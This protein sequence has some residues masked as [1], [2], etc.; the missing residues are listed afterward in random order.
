[1]GGGK[2]GDVL[3]A[4][5]LYQLG[6]GADGEAVEEVPVL[7]GHVDGLGVG[8][9]VD[10]VE[11]LEELGTGLR[12]LLDAG[13]VPD[14]LVVKDD[15][16]DREPR[17]RGLLAVE[18][19]GRVDVLRPVGADLLLEVGQVGQALGLRVGR[20]LSVAELDDVQRIRLR[21]C[22]GYLLLNSVPLLNF[23]LQLGSGLLFEGGRYVFGPPIRCG[24]VDS[25]DGQGFARPAA[26][27]GAF[28]VVAVRP[29]GRDAHQ[30]GRD[31]RRRYEPTLHSTL[32]KE[33][34]LVFNS[35]DQFPQLG[36]DL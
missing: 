29:T 2:V 19:G 24:T 5:L 34:E 26:R 10:G 16:A 12:Q 14:I 4:V 15:A 7:A 18:D 23:K 35:L 36:L 1:M 20:R 31:T 32:L 28:L 9:L 6:T 3:V 22:R 17:G 8:L 27:A 30:H 33:P 13:F 25:P 11:R 21:E